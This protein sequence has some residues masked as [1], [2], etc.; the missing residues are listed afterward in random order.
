VGPSDANLLRAR[1]FGVVMYLVMVASADSHESEVAALRGALRTLTGGR[2]SGA[3]VD[4]F[5]AEL[6]ERV[7]GEGL[8]S[9]ME[10][11]ASA[12]VGSAEDAELALSLAAAMAAADGEVDEAEHAAVLEFADLLGIGAKRRAA[13]LGSHGR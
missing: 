5:I 10:R 12:L 13:L 8:A 4:A 11:A 2:M 6:D 9:C 1:P 7:R 3:S